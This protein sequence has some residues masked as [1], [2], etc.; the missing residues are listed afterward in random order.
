VIANGDLNEESEF[1]IEINI[2]ASGKGRMRLRILL[3]EDEK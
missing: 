1:L 2:E 3:G